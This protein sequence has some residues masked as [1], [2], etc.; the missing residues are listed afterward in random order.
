MA[1]NEEFVKFLKHGLKIC[2]FKR[3]LE[4]EK[5]GRFP[6]HGTLGYSAL[7]LPRF[8]KLLKQER[9]E[10]NRIFNRIKNLSGQ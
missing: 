2:S 10:V 1:S 9:K 5:S 8:E 3:Y 4:K 7:S 6:R